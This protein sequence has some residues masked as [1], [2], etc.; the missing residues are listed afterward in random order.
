MNEKEKSAD[1]E[2]CAT[3]RKQIM[4]E[5]NSIE[6][7]YKYIQTLTNNTVLLDKIKV[8]IEHARRIGNY[9]TALK[10]KVAP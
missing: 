6:G 10:R 4:L 3:L 5:C 7:T 9:E 1:R 8:I 2:F